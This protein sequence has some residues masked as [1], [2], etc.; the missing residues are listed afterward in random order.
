MQVLGKSPWR[1]LRRLAM[2]GVV[3]FLVWRL[4]QTVQLLLI[5]LFLAGAIAPLVE[6]ME[7]YKIKRSVAV[8]IIYALILVCLILSVA[9]LPSLVS[10][11]GLFLT[12]LPE[13]INQI[14]LPEAPFWGL[15][16]RQLIEIIQPSVILNQIQAIGRELASQ[17][18][19]IT[20]RVINALGIGL[21]S[22]LITAY[23][24][25]NAEVL[26]KRALSPL[27]EEVRAQIYQLLPPITQCLSAYV[28]GRMG[29]SAL[30]GFCTYLVL[31]IVQVPFA[32][33]LGLLMAVANLIPFIGPFLGLI[34]MVIAAWN[35]GAPKV[36]TVIGVTFILQQI[37]A[38]ILQ[39]LLVGPYLNLDPFEL[40]LSVIIGT[41]LF[42][43]LGAIL[44]PPVAG[45]G[46][47][48]FNYFWGQ[49]LPSPP[50][51]S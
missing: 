19:E 47:I 13:L 18:V 42:G 44:A 5:S 21:L 34:P 45:I 6:R 27:S 35:L 22:L 46:R 3:I 31:S 41:E 43:I 36:I 25:I 49:S 4:Q 33:A 15:S 12:K 10:E 30:L 11:L 48:V 2:A 23:L 9:P 26:L 8:G 50:E 14:P 17:T 16:R 29:T 1:Y 39:P 7:K 40:L 51:D 38:W 37:E 24:V 20:F 32:G 28:L